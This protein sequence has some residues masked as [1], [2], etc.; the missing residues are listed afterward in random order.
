VPQEYR[1]H[2]DV[3]VRESPDAAVQRALAR[4]G[5][6]AGAID[7]V[8]GHRS[9]RAISHY[10]AEHGLRVSGNITPGLLRSLRIS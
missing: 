7:G 3:A 8:I 10:Q 1:A 2:D 9:R 4:R 6:Y 5:Y